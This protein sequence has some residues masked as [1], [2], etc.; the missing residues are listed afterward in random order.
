MQELSLTL[1]CKE[2]STLHEFSLHS[3]P[4]LDKEH[5]NINEED[6]LDDTWTQRRQH[7]IGFDLNTIIMTSLSI[8]FKKFFLQLENTPIF[9]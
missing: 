3:R 9:G 6:I 7:G 1:K 2:V 4:N 8:S 5:I